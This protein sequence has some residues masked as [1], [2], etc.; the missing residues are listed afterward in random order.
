MS[1]IVHRWDNIQVTWDIKLNF[2]MSKIDS[3]TAI[4][5]K[6]KQ[7]KL[8]FTLYVNWKLKDYEWFFSLEESESWLTLKDWGEWYAILN[9][10]TALWYKI[11]TYDLWMPWSNIILRWIDQLNNNEVLESF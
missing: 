10:F 5:S 4:E 8:I 2:S 11:W 6:Y 9:L 1:T 3:E 7:L